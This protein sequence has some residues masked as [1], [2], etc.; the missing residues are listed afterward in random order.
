VTSLD[1]VEAGSYSVNVG[2]SVHPVTVTRKAPYDPQ[3]TRIRSSA[4]VVG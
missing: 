4:G 1:W 3:G 2:G